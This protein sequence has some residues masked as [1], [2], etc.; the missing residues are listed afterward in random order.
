M[1]SSTSGLKKRTNRCSSS[2]VSSSDLS[3]L[4]PP[5]KLKSNDW[6]EL[7][8]YDPHREGD[9]HLASSFQN[10]EWMDD[11]VCSHILQFLSPRL[12]FLQYRRVCKQWL[13]FS[14]RLK[15]SFRNIENEEEFNF[16]RK[17][18]KMGYQIKDLEVSHITTI[19]MEEWD[20]LSRSLMKHARLTC[21]KITKC[22]II[23]AC[24][25]KIFSLQN[26]TQQLTQLDLQ[27]NSISNEGAQTISRC[28]HLNKLT[29]LNISMNCMIG[30]EGIHELTTSGMLENL[31][32]FILQRTNC[33]VRGVKSVALLN[34][35][36][37]LDMSKN[38]ISAEGVS[39][40]VQN[41]VL[42]L[43]LRVLK[44]CHCGLRSAG[45]NSLVSAEFHFTN[46]RHLDL[47]WNRLEDEGIQTL[48]SSPL[49]KQVRY[50]NLKLNGLSDKGAQCI[51][52]SRYVISLT[53]LNLGQNR[54]SNVGAL[55]LLRSEVLR[56]RLQ[57]LNLELNNINENKKVE[58]QL[59]Q[60]PNYDEELCDRMN[61]RV[62][63][64]L[65]VCLLKIKVDF[66]FWAGF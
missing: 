27:G 20:D 22:K 57:M 50:L 3:E 17:F 12:I 25:H 5:K 1:I 35:L 46:L 36:T 54:I 60:E 40:L 9:H 47:E 41:V 8:D 43:N 23:D 53:A 10:L 58:N 19:E 38:S 31:Q 11:L 49:L 64:H 37:H 21:L 45:I 2:L 55:A 56:P 65:T 32:S 6:F 44:M 34:N 18:L 26:T 14:R 63:E 7:N 48:S 62:E 4:D 39:N 30:D 51:A 61:S 33:S 29:Y 59:K 42:C 52:D 28:Q 15:Y 16:L 13:A 66:F 24:I